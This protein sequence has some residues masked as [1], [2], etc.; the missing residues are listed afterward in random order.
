[1]PGYPT[2]Q[3]ASAPAQETSRQLRCSGAFCSYTQ[4]PPPSY[5]AIS[6]TLKIIG[7]RNGAR[8][9]AARGLSKYPND[10]QLQALFRG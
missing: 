10:R 3:Q 6:E 1:M 2:V 8:F 4:W 9:W 5:V 7:D